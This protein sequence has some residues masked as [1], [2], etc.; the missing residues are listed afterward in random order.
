MVWCEYF[1]Q[2]LSRRLGRRLPLNHAIEKPSLKL[3]TQACDDLNLEYV[4]EGGKAYPAQWWKPSGRVLIDRALVQ[5]TKHQLIRR[6]AK[7]MR[8]NITN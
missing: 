8:E 4:S 3:L 2:S 1:D 6:L 7:R 5:G